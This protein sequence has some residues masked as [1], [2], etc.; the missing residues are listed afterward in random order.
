[1]IELNE[2]WKHIEDQYLNPLVY[3]T[4]NN[5]EMRFSEPKEFMRVYTYIYN[6]CNDT[7]DLNKTEKINN[8]L[9]TYIQSYVDSLSNHLSTFDVDY[10]LINYNRTWKD[11]KNVVKWIAKLFSYLES[12]YYPYTKYKNIKEM[13]YELFKNTVISKL[14]EKDIDKILDYHIAKLLESNNDEIKYF[15]NSLS[16]LG[17]ET[18]YNNLL[19][20]IEENLYH[21]YGD[22]VDTRP[23]SLFTELQ[24][25]LDEEY[26]I[27]S[28][29][30]NESDVPYVRK[31]ILDITLDKNISQFSF[32]DW[33]EVLSTTMLI[34][35]LIRF[36]ENRS[37]R[38]L[39]EQVYNFTKRKLS[40][41]GI[42]KFDSCVALYQSLVQ[43]TT[44]LDI[45]DAL[46]KALTSLVEDDI[47]K[48]ISFID[49]EIKDKNYN[50]SIFSKI[51]DNLV[52]KDSFIEIYSEYA[53]KRLLGDSVDFEIEIEY[54][55]IL[56]K[57][58]GNAVTSKLEG[59]V[60]DIKYN[61]VSYHQLEVKVL[62]LSVWS[63][64]KYPH[65]RSTK[66]DNFI[67]QY[68]QDYYSNYHNRKLSWNYWLGNLILRGHYT[69]DT[70]YIMNMTTSQGLVLL[71]IS[72]THKISFKSLCEK[73]GLTSEYLKPLVHSLYATKY[74]LIT[75]SGLHN[76]IT[77]DDEIQINEDFS[78]GS[79]NIKLPTPI[80][81]IKKVETN[82][83]ENRAI[84]IDSII[85]R[86]M[87]T[88]KIMLH[89]NLC[90]S[91][92]LEIKL[93]QATTNQIK[94]RIETLISKE[95]IERDSG[96]VTRYLYVA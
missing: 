76:K 50:T 20:Q 41:V 82:L 68:E 74:K 39:K 54:L 59:M 80:I 64:I 79:K 67:Q 31:I 57:I 42:G 40:L 48:F 72:D 70:K 34:N 58:C 88:N 27:Y 91:V 93:F 62:T 14:K 96:D 18:I 16:E 94:K 69:D 22:F 60:K 83:E 53:A 55:M 23:K 66:L 47:D 19:K 17:D 5:V 32:E 30:L 29:V 49:K 9:T 45:E 90:E 86:I 51:V 87:K 95:Y 3:Y 81:N 25:I 36:Y 21:Q 75:K 65:I 73:L 6:V 1:M 8:L 26:N 44:Y 11:F 85:V 78:N 38:I 89:K 7:K 92:M 77:D 43:L 2:S 24:V 46:D 4:S 10:L 63:N 13:C 52:A 37:K 56:K 35:I 28:K 33:E 84:L 71:E 15:L 61:T 12:Y